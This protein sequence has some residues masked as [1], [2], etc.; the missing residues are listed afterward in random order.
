MS[1]LEFAARFAREDA[2]GRDGSHDMFHVERVMRLA[3]TLAVQEKVDNI[4]VVQLAALLHDVKDY[5]YSRSETAQ[6]EAIRDFLR[7]HNYPEAALELVVRIVKGVG[8]KGEIA[9]G[10]KEMFPELAVVQDAD[11]LEAIGAI[12]IART[13]AFGGA[14]GRP[15]YDPSQKPRADLSAEEY[16]AQKNAPTLNH[17]YEKLLK[18]KDLMKTASGRRLAEQRHAFMLSFL[19]EFYREWDGAT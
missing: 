13:F 8:F 3:T 17:F 10:Q 5:K 14:R 16:A 19:D 7:H 4:E 9:G 11:R 12:G 15:L 2:Q 18:L 6:E 1:I